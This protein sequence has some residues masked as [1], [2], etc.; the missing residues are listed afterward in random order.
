VRKAALFRIPVSIFQAGHGTVRKEGG[1]S[2]HWDG[3]Q[4]YPRKLSIISWF[5]IFIANIHCA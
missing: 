2:D 4:K 3:K 5:K 1:H